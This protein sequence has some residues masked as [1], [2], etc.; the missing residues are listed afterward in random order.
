[1]SKA[2]LSTHPI[3]D[4]ADRRPDDQFRTHPLHPDAFQPCT[5]NRAITFPEFQFANLLVCGAQD[6]GKILVPSITVIVSDK[7][8]ETAFDQF[9]PVNT[10]DCCAGKISFKD[11]RMFRESQV[12]DRGKFIQVCVPVTG[13]FKGALRFTEGLVL[14][15][16]LDLVDTK[17]VYYLC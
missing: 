6:T 16:Q 3:S 7:Y 17:L 2:L 1:V 4:I 11:Y 15:F 13:F 14:H 9:P 8:P 12:P 10:K 5:D